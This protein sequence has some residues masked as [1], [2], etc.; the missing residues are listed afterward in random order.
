MSLFYEATS[1]TTSSSNLTPY[2]SLS[3]NTKL[4]YD[5]DTNNSNYKLLNICYQYNSP[6]LNSDFIINSNDK[7]KFIFPDNPWAFIFPILI[8]FL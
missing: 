4:L 3:A 2:N 1:T 5:F 7:T 8:I 6:A